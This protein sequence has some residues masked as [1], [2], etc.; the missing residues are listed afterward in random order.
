MS[1]VKAL[2]DDVRGICILIVRGYPRRQKEYKLR[3][4]EL[5][6]YTPDN[7]VTIR[8]PDNPNDERKHEGALI[9]S[10]HN[11]SRTAEDITERIL[12]LDTLPETQ[13]MYAVEYAVKRI[14]RDIPEDMRK[15]LA[16]AI[17]QNCQSGKK[18]PFKVLDIDGFSER[19]FY[20]ERDK[21]LSDIAVFLKLV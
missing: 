12:G 10:A 15:K 17:F 18:Y 14:R 1:R 4:D 9:P 11:A 7:I 6:N 20:R 3:R 5:M 19:G 8:D 2:P 16:Q 13:R 21:F